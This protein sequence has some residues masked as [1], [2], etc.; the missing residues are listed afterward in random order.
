MT[1]R[2]DDRLRAL[3]QSTPNAV[4]LIDDDLQL[5]S[6]NPA[7][8]RLFGPAITEMAGRTAQVLF[9]YP[10]D[11]E[12][13]SEAG[14]GLHHDRVEHSFTARYRSLPGRVFDGETVA[15]RIEAEDPA[16]APEMMLIIRD[17]S[18][19]LTLKAKLEASDIQLRAAL[20][21]ANE[22]AFSLNLVTGLGSTRGFINEFLGIGT[23]DATI[24]L[25]RWLD[26][27]EPGMRDQ[28]DA[29]IQHLRTHPTEALDSVFQAKRA[30]G[31]WRWL[32][33]RGRVTEFMRDGHLAA[34][35]PA[36]SPTSP[37]ARRWKKSWPNGNASWP[38]P[39]RP[40]PAGSGNSARTHGKSR[41]SAKYADMLGLAEDEDPHS[42]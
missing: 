15:V 10:K 14:F 13:L 38:M 29:A 12:R 30:D 24:S 26:V 32:H 25:E 33:M 37:T 16:K 19:E 40:A 34:G 23:T 20:A 3:Y 8:Q 39:S 1:R 28:V 22:G 42:R 4:I 18:S 41:P 21:S 31:E 35:V 2:S 6:F 36:S 11:F 17:A 9:A 5:R 7:A 27:V